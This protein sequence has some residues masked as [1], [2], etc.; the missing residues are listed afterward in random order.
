MNVFLS[1]F[2]EGY[3]PLTVP[4]IKCQPKMYLKN[5]KFFF[6]FRFFAVLGRFLVVFG[7]FSG[8]LGWIFATLSSFRFIIKVTGGLPRRNVI[9]FPICNCSNEWRCIIMQV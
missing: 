3:L 4:T 7:L 9:L 6:F 5:G 8:F 1:K 2:S